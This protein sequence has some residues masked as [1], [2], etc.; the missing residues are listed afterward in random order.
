M[1]RAGRFRAGGLRNAERDLDGVQGGFV[2]SGGL[3]GRGFIDGGFIDGIFVNGCLI[4]GSRGGFIGRTGGRV[5]RVRGGAVRDRTG[6]D[7]G[8]IRGRGC[9]DGCSGF[10][11]GEGEGRAHRRHRHQRDGRL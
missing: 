2:D 1:H 8:F 11:A 10:H 5:C 3:V 4:G 9:L 6:E 7:G